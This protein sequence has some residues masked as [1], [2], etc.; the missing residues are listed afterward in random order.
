VRWVEQ[1]NEKYQKFIL[2]L[3]SEIPQLCT[4]VPR[5]ISKYCLIL[6]N[7]EY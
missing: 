6:S 2:Y 3:K 7:Y 4:A 1:I 5:D